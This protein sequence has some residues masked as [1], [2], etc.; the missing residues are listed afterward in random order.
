MTVTSA[1]LGV[2]Y[3][4]HVPQARTDDDGTTEDGTTEDSH[5]DFLNLIVDIIEAQVNSSAEVM[6]R[7]I[8]KCSEFLFST[9]VK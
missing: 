7:S 6:M 9:S 4:T 2:S 5:V 3:L 1:V 8:W